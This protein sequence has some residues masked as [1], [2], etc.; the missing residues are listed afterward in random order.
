MLN[1]DGLTHINDVDLLLM[2][3][4]SRELQE[5]VH[6]ACCTLTDHHESSHNLD[7]SYEW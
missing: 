2:I 7:T 1:F 4:T 3:S 6:T 5:S